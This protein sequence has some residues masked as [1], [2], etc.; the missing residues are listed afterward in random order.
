MRTRSQ[1]GYVTFPRSHGNRTRSSSQL[2]PGRGSLRHPQEGGGSA[3]CRRSGLFPS[4]SSRVSSQFCSDWEQ[5]HRKRASVP[6]L[7]RCVPSPVPGQAPHLAF[8][9]FKG[10]P[11]SLSTARCKAFSSCRIS[12]STWGDSR[13]CGRAARVWGGQVGEVR[14][15]AEGR[16]RTGVSEQSRTSPA[17]V[18]GGHQPS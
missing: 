10:L 5:A 9:T 11:S 14:V 2:L 18:A 1:R 6:R 4:S 8:G 13:A 7:P 16:R 15:G 12:S 3:T 17:K